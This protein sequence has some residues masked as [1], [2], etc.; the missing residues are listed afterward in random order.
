VQEAFRE[1]HRERGSL[2]ARAGGEQR[3][4]MAMVLPLR[5]SQLPL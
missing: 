2:E 5:G 3:G 1:L 4:L